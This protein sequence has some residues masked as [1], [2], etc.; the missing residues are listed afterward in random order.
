[1]KRR[2]RRS[3]ERARRGRWGRRL[4]RLAV[5]LGVLALL[6]LGG[7]AWLYHRYVVVEPGE[8][9]SRASI[10]AIIAQESPVLYR[11][12]RTPIGVF[13]SREHR[14]YVPYDEIPR[15][16][17]DAIVAAED[18]RFFEH[19]GVDLRG[20]ARAMWM[21]LRAGR[22][23][24]GG[25]TL[26]QQTAK[27]L[28]YRPDR[29]LRSKW[30]ELVDA[31][32]LEAHYSKRDI[33]EFYANQFHVNANGRGLGIAAR[34]FF[35]KDP[36]ELSTL[37]CA[38]IAGMV[39]APAT[40][41]PFLARTPERR[42]EA[43][44]RARARTRYVLDRMLATGRLSRAE[45]DR[46]V[47]EPIPFRRGTFRYDANV[48]LDAVAARLE[49]APFPE[50]FERL[51]IDNPSTAGIQVVTTLDPAV[52]REATWGLWHHLSEVGPLLEGLD[53]AA[54]RLPD[55]AAPPPVRDAPPAVHAFTTGIVRSRQAGEAPAL[56][57]DLGGSTCTVDGRAL[58]RMASILA[59]ARS[60]DPRAT[61]RRGDVDALAAALP[62]GSVV[63]VSVRERGPEGAYCDLEVR[64][65]LQ[66][67]VLVLE[68]G[69]VRAMVGGN[70]NR[71]FNRALD[72]KRQLGS[73]W[74]PI[75]YAT[76]LHL[77]W[78][79]LDV[80]D[81]RPAFFVFEG[82]WYAPRAAHRSADF[83][84]LAW[85]GVHSENIASIWLL[86][87]LV[88]R[89]DER[90]FREL[91]AAVGLDRREGEGRMAWI[92]R[93]RDGYGIVAT[94][95]RYPEQAW[96]A[97]RQE[98]VAELEARAAGPDG[99]E[100]P[101]LAAEI[102]ELRS[103]RWGRGVEA[104]EARQRKRHRGAE[105]A[106]RLAALRRNH[107]HLSALADRCAGEAEALDALA[108]A[109][110]KAARWAGLG[111]LGSLRP[112]PPA[113]PPAADFADLRVRPWGEDGLALACGAA[114][115][116]WRPVD[117]E[118]LDALAR[119][120]GPRP[121]EPERMWVDGVLRLSTIRALER[122]AARHLA[123]LDNADPYDL[124]ALRW[125]PDFRLLVAMR[126]MAAEARALGVEQDLPPVLSLPL[127]AVDISLEE[128]ATVYQGLVSG[129][130]WRFPGARFE[131]SGIAG[132]RAA[133]PVAEPE[134]D[135]LLI[136][137]IRDR[138]GN[139]IYQA[140]PRLDPRLDP[141]ASREIGGILRD[142]VRFGTGRRAEGAVRV[143]GRPV[144][145]A[146]KTGTTNGYR[147]AA[148][149]GFVPRYSADGWRWGDG[150][151]VAAWVGYDDN[152]PM[153]RGRVRLQGSSGALPAW[154]GVARGLAEAG[155]LGDGPGPDAPPEA[156]GWA[157]GEGLLR[158]PVDPATGLRVA[159]PAGEGRDA[160]AVVVAGEEDDGRPLPRRR[161]LPPGA[162]PSA[163]RELGGPGLPEAEEAAPGAAEGDTGLVPRIA[164][165]GP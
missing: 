89:L 21:N 29:S 87:H 48:V 105:L 138:E 97:A 7:L 161:F 33:L 53:A 56:E 14:R 47:E 32:R 135:T 12:G 165:A 101:D 60:G 157:L 117:A 88:D 8:H 70:D 52:Q 116:A 124:D 164:P 58:E 55:S 159:A 30:I 132:L 9:I 148:F 107:R 151:V 109:G 13:F 15:A 68:D 131:G 106:W 5:A 42:E 73:T 133:R 64:P 2:E 27:N 100:D 77:G 111:I 115:E 82:S 41:N 154:L 127:G 37:E 121:V 85:A 69:A 65:E 3:E 38:Y 152:R 76:A 95:D 44:A 93:I 80:L 11:D 72:A 120:E 129:G 143:G 122:A 112:R 40:Y 66:G 130:R 153:R 110:R 103:L 84:S 94:R 31:L 75:L 145:L 119:G 57:V 17:I 155:L 150:W 54:L 83:V 74:K 67:A 104:E 156:D 46:L 10:E 160:P 163:L 79:P 49:R 147:N 102:R 28:F 128:A 137:E 59:R 91:V 26:T 23:V 125:H 86:A 108:E 63:R 134:D 118:L 62:A 142:V 25:S 35:D 81:N 96:L 39:K 19:H 141:A 146:G 126:A 51:G 78:S 162:D 16:W 114:D 34:Y 22:V 18:E 43:L 158:V 6:G 4:V 99:A 98:L 149:T 139:V 36:A 1:M 144:P 113:V 24:A 136:A 50:L 45:H 123:V 92:E 20:I 61:A 90:A 71:N 140:R